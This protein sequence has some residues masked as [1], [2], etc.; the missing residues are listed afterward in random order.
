M[1]GIERLAQAQATQRE[2]AQATQRRLASGARWISSF[3]RDLS[4]EPQGSLRC[5]DVARSVVFFDS[6]CCWV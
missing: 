3:R 4:Q 2:Q 6:T 5:E 1:V